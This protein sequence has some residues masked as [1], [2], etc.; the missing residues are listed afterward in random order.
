MRTILAAALLALAFVHAAPMAD[1]EKR[2]G[3]NPTVGQGW[4]RA[5]DIVNRAGDEAGAAEWKRGSAGGSAGRSDWK[6]G[7]SAIELD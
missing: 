4:K 5:V 3:T 1:L 7:E 6:R 2:V